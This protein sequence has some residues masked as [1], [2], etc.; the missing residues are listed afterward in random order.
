MSPAD[1]TPASPEA[2]QRLYD[3]LKSMALPLQR[4]S[5]P[6]LVVYSGKDTFI[7]PEWTRNAIERACELG[8]TI[9]SVFQ[10]DKEHGDLGP[11]DLLVRWL[12]ERFAGQPAT[13][14]CNS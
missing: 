7:Q 1:L 8:D 12:G 14:T 13:N 10:A 2:Q 4:A 6:M 9:Q 5:A 11:G 3:L